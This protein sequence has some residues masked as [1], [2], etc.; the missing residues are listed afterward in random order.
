MSNQKNPWWKLSAKEQQ[1]AASACNALL[2][3]VEN[4]EAT[5]TEVFFLK[6]H[7]GQLLG[8]RIRLKVLQEDASQVISDQAD[9][10]AF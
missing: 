1:E 6:N 7:L 3:S 8:R 10:P 9:Y 2:A 5:L 4:P